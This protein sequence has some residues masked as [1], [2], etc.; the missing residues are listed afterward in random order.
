MSTHYMAILAQKIREIRHYPKTRL[1]SALGH[2]NEIGMKRGVFAAM[3]TAIAAKQNERAKRKTTPTLLRAQLRAAIERRLTRRFDAIIPLRQ[4]ASN[5]GGESGSVKVLLAPGRPS[6]VTFSAWKQWSGNG[7][8]C[9]N[10]TL[11]TMSINP[12]DTFAVIGG[13]LTI[14]PKRADRGQPVPCSW[15]VQK[16]GF[17]FSEHFGYLI[18]DYHF[19]GD[20]SGALE[21]QA[22]RAKSAERRAKVGET[23]SVAGL[24][25]KFGWCLT[26]INNF[27]AI[28]GISSTRIRVADLAKIVAENPEQNAKFSA[29]LKKLNIYVP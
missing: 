2:P 4:S 27:R 22:K 19:E 14:F 23:V 29:Y 9:G 28:N 13:M 12:A 7:K 25:Q 16:R 20:F 3:A 24:N 10:V 15:Y 21:C 18:G 11:H 5:W 17:D 1:V 26:G 8:W 6:T